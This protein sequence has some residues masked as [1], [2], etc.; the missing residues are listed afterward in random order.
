M[1]RTGLTLLLSLLAGAGVAAIGMVTALM[2]PL[3]PVWS[4]AR[5]GTRMGLA[6]AFASLAGAL[7]AAWIFGTLTVSPWG[8]L[9]IVT[10]LAGGI[11][12]AG[13]D[14]RQHR[15]RQHAEERERLARYTRTIAADALASRF[16]HAISSPLQAAMLLAEQGHQNRQDQPPDPVSL[17]ED[18]SLIHDALGEAAELL[19]KLRAPTRIADADIARLDP[20]HELNAAISRAHEDGLDEHLVTLDIAPNLSTVQIERD[21][22]A[23]I[24]DGL[25]ADARNALAR[26]SSAR[27]ALVMRCSLDQNRYVFSLDG[28]WR[29]VPHAWSDH[30]DAEAM[31]PSSIAIA[32]LLVE[33]AGGTI[34]YETRPDGICLWFSLPMPE[35]DTPANSRR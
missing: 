5:H 33:R 25:I 14:A 7:P 29:E 32:R 28:P 9:C 34:G 16:N 3:I 11:A 26:S 15:R 4:G 31:E 2:L 8:V 27:H 30:A 12:G 17:Q 19:R 18:I 35:Q 23:L 22:L 1:T 6:A 20:G 24:Y 10:L 13:Y 21:A